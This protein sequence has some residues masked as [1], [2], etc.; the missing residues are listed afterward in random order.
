MREFPISLSTR[1]V[2]P[3]WSARKCVHSLR[4]VRSRTSLSARDSHRH[5]RIMEAR[6]GPG[7]NRP[8]LVTVGIHRPRHDKTAVRAPVREVDLDLEVAMGE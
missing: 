7:M 4:F 6:S 3:E 5:L 2:M 1:V 8:Q